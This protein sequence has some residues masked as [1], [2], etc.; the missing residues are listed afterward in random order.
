MQPSIVF[1]ADHSYYRKNGIYKTLP[2]KQPLRLLMYRIIGM[3]TAIPP[4]RR[5]VQKNMKELMLMPYR[6]V[7]EKGP[8][9]Q[10]SP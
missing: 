8:P 1:P 5:R 10:V 4:L 2:H 3:V 6:A 7:V 9:E